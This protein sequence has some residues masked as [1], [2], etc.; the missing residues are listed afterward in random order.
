[1][2]L[3]RCTGNLKTPM[4]NTKAKPLSSVACQRSGNV[5][6][7]GPELP[8]PSDQAAGAFCCGWNDGPCGSHRGRPAGRVAGAAWWW[9]RTSRAAAGLS[10]AEVARAQPDGYTIGLANVATTAVNPAINPRTPTTR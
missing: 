3:C 7:P 1:M 2:S 8:Q 9:W 10:A 6:G 4:K 5:V